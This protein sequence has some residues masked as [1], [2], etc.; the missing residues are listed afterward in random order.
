MDV[1]HIILRRTWL[2]DLDVTIYGRTNHYSFV[3]NGKKVKLMPNQLKPPTAEKKIDKSKWKMVMNLITLD[4]FEQSLNKGLTCYSLVTQETEPEI[5]LQIQ[6][7]I[8]LIPEKFSDVLPKDL[9]S[10]L[11][12][13]RDIQHTIDLVPRVTLSY[14]SHYRMNPTENAELQR[15]V[16]E[17]LDKGFIRESLIP[18]RFS[19]F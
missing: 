9:R 13:T 10:E 5:E 6:R 2:F 3:H 4:R 18:V 19:H 8:K 17:L 15:H 12:L 7:Y 11:P 16:E 1:D 14:L